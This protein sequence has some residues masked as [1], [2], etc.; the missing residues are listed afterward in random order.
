MSR[1]VHLAIHVVGFM[2]HF[3]K[4]ICHTFKFLDIKGCIR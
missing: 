3:F 1:V 2:S 4:E